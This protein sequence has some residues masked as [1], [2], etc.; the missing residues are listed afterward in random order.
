MI[1]RILKME[2][3]YIYRKLLFYFI[4]L[5]KTLMFSLSEYL[6]RRQPGPGEGREALSISSE[7]GECLSRF[8][9]SD[10]QWAVLSQTRRGT[11]S[12]SWCCPPRPPPRTPRGTSCPAPW[13]LCPSLDPPASN[14]YVSLLG[15]TDNSLLL[16]GLRKF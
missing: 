12:G 9:L 16:S 6:S 13:L 11:P 4:L 15:N 10:C 1:Y 3:F 5:P 7:V 8:W 2:I 14:K